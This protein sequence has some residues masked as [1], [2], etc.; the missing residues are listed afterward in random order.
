MRYTSS[1]KVNR[2]KP[3]AISP[4][5]HK[6]LEQL[7]EIEHRG[8][9]HELAFLVERRCRELNLDPDT[10]QPIAALSAD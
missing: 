3:V 1:M 6:L 2:Y 7:C 9:I 4:E 5:T 8:L 10:L